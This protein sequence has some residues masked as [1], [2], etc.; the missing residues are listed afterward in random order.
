MASAVV[1]AP[2]TEPVSA[3]S[4]ITNMFFAPSK[5][6]RDLPRNSSW[7]M[8][9]LLISVFGMLFVVAV[10]Q[11]VGWDRA[12]QNMIDSNPKLSANLEK[13]PAEQRDRQT[14][15]IT[16]STQYSSY[17]VPIFVL[18]FAAITAAVLMGVF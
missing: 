10:G 18:V 11:K 8:A 4:R 15:I 17:A 14:S 7:W 2:P 13:M 12:A 1:P 3:V 9:W 6:F 5:T 16:K